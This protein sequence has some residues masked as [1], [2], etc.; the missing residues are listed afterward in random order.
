MSTEKGQKMTLKMSTGR[1]KIP[2][3]FILRVILH[4]NFPLRI[5][6][7]QVSAKESEVNRH[8]FGRLL[9]QNHQNPYNQDFLELLVQIF[10]VSCNLHVQSRPIEMRIFHRNERCRIS[11]ILR[12]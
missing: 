6:G 10:Y 4:P 1:N 7:W 8:K 11:A 3:Y 5:E 2:L 12:L 9:G